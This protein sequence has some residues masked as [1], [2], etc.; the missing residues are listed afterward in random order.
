MSTLGPQNYNTPSKTRKKMS[1]EPPPSG[2]TVAPEPTKAEIDAVGPAKKVSVARSRLE[3]LFDPGTFEE[4]DMFVE[5]RCSEFDMNS[6][7]IPG[8]GV[9]IG[10]GLIN[11]RTVFVYVKDFTVFGGS[12][13]L[14]HSKKIN[15]IQ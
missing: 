5:H 7:K 14:A 13:S 11:G 6:Q 9:V 1:S 8:D 2:A 12:L 4:W 3:A 10:S 15:K